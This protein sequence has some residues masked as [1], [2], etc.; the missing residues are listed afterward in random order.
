L[1]ANQQKRI[2]EHENLNVSMVVVVL[3]Y[4]ETIFSEPWFDGDVNLIK[5]NFVMM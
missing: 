1:L 2:S 3:G 5:L 4:F